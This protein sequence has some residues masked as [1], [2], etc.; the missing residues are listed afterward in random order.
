MVIDR[1]AV[2][3]IKKYKLDNKLKRGVF[4]YF[5]V[6]YKLLS[7]STYLYLIRIE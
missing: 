3:L 1:I 6:A 5:H 7:C 4:F 2:Y